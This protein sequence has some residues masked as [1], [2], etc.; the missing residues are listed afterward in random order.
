[1]ELFTSVIF[2]MIFAGVANVMY[3]AVPIV[4]GRKVPQVFRCVVI[5]SLLPLALVLVTEAFI[6]VALFNGVEI[7]RLWLHVP[8]PIGDVALIAGPPSAANLVVLLSKK[9]FLPWPISWPIASGAGFTIAVFMW[10]QFV[11]FASGY[12][13]DALR[14]V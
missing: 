7:P 9:V 11:F 6:L 4:L 8:F 14:S 12:A 3:P 2:G 13:D 10:V 5:I 1:M